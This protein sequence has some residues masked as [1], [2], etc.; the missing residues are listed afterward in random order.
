M[1]Q[2][3]LCHRVRGL[4]DLWTC[5][6]WAWFGMM[7][8]D[9]HVACMYFQKGRC[10]I[11]LDCW[12]SDQ[13]VYSILDCASVVWSR[14]DFAFFF[15]TFCNSLN[16]ND[17]REV[18]GSLDMILA[19]RIWSLRISCLL[20]KR[21]LKSRWHSE[22]ARRWLYSLIIINLSHSLSMRMGQFLNCSTPR[23]H[24]KIID[25]GLAYEFKDDVVLPA[26]SWHTLPALLSQD[27]PFHLH[28]ACQVN[29]KFIVWLQMPPFENFS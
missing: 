20:P 5:G 18:D 15:L 28:K 8:M 9:G 19:P 12:F 24:L 14:R 10:C 2:R 13:R 4:E 6:L 3:K 1:H 25:F 7:Q 22:G 23:T 29:L 11:W 26:I 16:C 27:C 17:G 21:R